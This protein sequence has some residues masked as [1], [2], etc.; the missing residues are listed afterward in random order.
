MSNETLKK[1]EIVFQKQLNKTDRLYI[2]LGLDSDNEAKAWVIPIF[3]YLNSI[4]GFR[5]GT[6]I[7]PMIVGANFLS[8]VNQEPNLTPEVERYRQ[9]L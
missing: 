1:G 7:L 8:R 2:Y 3:Q 5:A 6:V 9:E 4:Y